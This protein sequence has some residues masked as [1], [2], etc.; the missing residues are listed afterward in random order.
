[1]ERLRI[2]VA[3]TRRDLRIEVRSR[4]VTN[5]ILPFAAVVMVVFAFALDSDA[6]LQR[7]APGLVLMATLFSMLVLVQRSYAIETEDGAFD[8]LRLSGVDPV[9]LFWGKT[10]SLTVQMVVLEVLLVAAAV[11]L[12]TTSI[13]GSGWVMVIL[14]LVLASVGL[15]AV[16]T[17]YGGLSAGFSGRETLLPLLVLP[18][19]SPVV[20]G[21]A[22]ALESGFGTA[23]AVAADGWPW[24]ALLA[25]FTVTFG[26]GGS[27]AYGPLIEE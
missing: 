2:A 27:L 22:R 4:I 20:I 5:Q 23:G 11:T 25:V 10:L 13:P 26:I 12:Y 8:L 14:T 21:A 17:L 18:V 3:I 15:A 1:M 9:A 16:G 24:L 7:V 19:V 6:V